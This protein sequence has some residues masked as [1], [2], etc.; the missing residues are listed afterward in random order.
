MGGRVQG[1]RT[2]P[3]NGVR[4]PTAR[5]D[6]WLITRHRCRNVRSCGHPRVIAVCCTFSSPGFGADSAGPVVVVVVYVV[7]AVAVEALGFLSAV[8]L[9]P[10]R[11]VGSAV[12]EGVSCLLRPRPHPPRAPVT[13]LVAACVTISFDV[14]RTCRVRAASPSPLCVTPP[15]DVSVN[16]YVTTGTGT[17]VAVSDCV[18]RRHVTRGVVLG[19]A[20]LPRVSRH[21]GHAGSPSVTALG[22]VTQS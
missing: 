8:V 16:V 17:D 11:R 7:V 1:A 19:H 10:G 6:A 5:S 14:T 13:V 15:A 4:T 18:T 12:D 3:G 21:A 20:S 9:V 22:D 2:V